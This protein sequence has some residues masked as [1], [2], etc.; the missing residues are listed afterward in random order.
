M[1]ETEGRG[2][3]AGVGPQARPPGARRAHCCFLVSSRS[4]SHGTA[5][6]AS[7]H[8]TQAGKP[9]ALN[10]KVGT[11][12]GQGEQAELVPQTRFPFCKAALAPASPGSPSLPASLC[13]SVSPTC[14]LKA[15][16]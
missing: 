7:D 2:G 5:T 4:F 3:A 10:P 9:Q 1:G 16:P 11:A 13:A 14:P 15:T 8:Q 12:W 6:M